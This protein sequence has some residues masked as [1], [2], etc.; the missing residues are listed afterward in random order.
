MKSKIR[1]IIGLFV[2]ILSILIGSYIGLYN[3]IIMTLSKLGI[4]YS[5]NTVTWIMV[6]FSLIK[7]VFAI[8]VFLFIIYVGFC[9]GAI[10]IIKTG[11]QKTSKTSQ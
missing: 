1:G 5:S 7:L 3:M 4:A 10:I 2:M 11:K 8:P 6:S 9:F